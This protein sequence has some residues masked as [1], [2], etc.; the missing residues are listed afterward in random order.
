VVR[1]LTHAPGDT[2]AH[3]GD[4]TYT[5]DGYAE[6]LFAIKNRT[7]PQD[8]AERIADPLPL[9]I[10]GM[11]RQG[12]AV[13]RHVFARLEGFDAG[14]RMLSDTAFFCQLALEGPFA[15][16]GHT[17]AEIRRLPGDAEAITS[18][19]RKNA[20][21]ARQMHVRGL[22]ALAARRLPS[23]QQKLADRALS[24]AEFRLAQALHGRDPRAARALL[25]Q[26]ARRHPLA[27]QRLD[28]VPDRRYHGCSRLPLGSVRQQSGPQLRKSDVRDPDDVLADLCVIALVNDDASLAHNLETSDLLTRQGVPLHIE[29]GAASA[30]IGYNAGLDATTAGIVVLAHQDVYFPPGWH[31]HLARA[32]ADVERIDPDWAVLAP[33]GMCAETDAHIGDV[34]STGISR[35][36]GERV[37][38]PRAVQ[39][40]DELVIVLRRASGLRFDPALPRYHLYGTDLV[41]MAWA[42][43]KGAY[44]AAMPVVHND[45]FKAAL[46]ADFT[47][48]YA[49]VRRK[50]RA[51][52]PLRTPVLWVTKRGFGLLRYRFRAWRGLSKRR[53]LA[54]DTAVSPKVYAVQCG[55]EDAG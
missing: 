21:Y 23:G 37:S 46:G 28:Q 20:V 8:H 33:F 1:D 24:G 4:V 29:R 19:H 16:T 25:W 49:F 55:W 42:A 51:M 39:S 26:A 6:Q 38:A 5:G 41:Q 45:D 10:S 22:A 14:M 50:W 54:G 13:R 30:S 9:V 12:A 43:G 3:L 44:V 17:L 15:V 18:L 48:S 35:R 52:L 11:T 27:P 34:W 31:V 53:A 7:F 40:V 32:I 2:V 47:E 36:V